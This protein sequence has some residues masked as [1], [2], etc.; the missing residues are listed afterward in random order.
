MNCLRS[1]LPLG[2]LLATT[3]PAHA[4]INAMKEASS[5]PSAAEWV[6]IGAV[7]SMLAALAYFAFQKRPAPKSKFVMKPSTSSKAKAPHV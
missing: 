1:A 2:L 5:T 6:V 3:Q 7:G 4:C